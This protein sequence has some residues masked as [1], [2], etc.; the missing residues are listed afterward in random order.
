MN[1]IVKNTATKQMLPIFDITK[2]QGGIKSQPLS[3]QKSYHKIKPYL[4]RVTF[5][6]S[7]KATLL[8]DCFEAQAI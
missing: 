6:S 2:K 5:V 3:N 8:L 7:L 4:S 1:L